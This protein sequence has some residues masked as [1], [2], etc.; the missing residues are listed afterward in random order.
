[1]GFKSAI[2]ALVSLIK[3]SHSQGPIFR[4]P[5]FGPQLS[6]DG[7]F[8]FMWRFG[9]F[10]ST[11]AFVLKKYRPY[12][13][14]EL[15]HDMLSDKKSRSL[16]KKRYVMSTHFPLAAIGFTIEIESDFFYHSEIFARAI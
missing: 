9:I 6:Y 4:Q 12:I 3:S 8:F 2:K 16:P 11:K 7:D 5:P 13:V 15:Q 1:M 10:L 14:L